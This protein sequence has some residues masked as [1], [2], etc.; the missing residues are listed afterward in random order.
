MLPSQWRKLF[1]IV[2]V[3]AVWVMTLLL[4]TKPFTQTFSASAVPALGGVGG[5]CGFCGGCGGGGV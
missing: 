1:R 2:V 5:V 4:R 3:D